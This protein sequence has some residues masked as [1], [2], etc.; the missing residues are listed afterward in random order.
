MAN[1]KMYIDKVKSRT[2]LQ[3]ERNSI[4]V[5]DVTIDFPLVFDGNGKMY[6]FKL[7]RYVYVKGTRYTKADGKTRDFLM[8]CLFKRGFMS[9]GASAPSFAQFVVPDIKAGNDVYNSAPFIH[10]G[11]YM[12]KGTIEGADLTREECDDVLRGIWRIAGMS[13]LVAGAADLGIHV[14]AGSSDHWGNDS[15]N[16]KHLFKAKFEYR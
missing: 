16:C 9:D 12:C 14:F 15:N 8:T 3:K 4:T 7:D 2:Y 6:F 10:D 13:R 11:L 5:D 1:L